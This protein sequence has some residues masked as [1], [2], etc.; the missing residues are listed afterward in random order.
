VI[1]RRRREDWLSDADGAAGGLLPGDMAAAARRAAL[2]IGKAVLVAR[3]SWTGDHADDVGLLCEELADEIALDESRRANLLA[4][5]QLHDIGKLTLP[6]SILQKPGPLT[7]AEWR[8]VRDHTPAGERIISA[9]PELTYV[10]R[11]VR[12]SHEHWDG[13][14]Y[15]DG[16]VGEDIPIESRIIL[17]ADAFHAVRSPRPYR[18]GRSARKALE[19]IQAHAGGQFDPHVVRAL[20]RVV[21]KLR[22]SQSERFS[23]SKST[24]L[25]SRR[26]AA[27]LLSSRSSAPPS[28]ARR[29]ERPAL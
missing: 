18:P 6:E 29:S 12:H 5:A 24:R 1:Y 9:V 2:E 23:S 3:D 8:A 27:L 26:L 7:A 13:G 25:R 16:L 20:E 10:G 4:A 21:E 14:G 22:A 11:I 17:C 28:P 15:P 19:E